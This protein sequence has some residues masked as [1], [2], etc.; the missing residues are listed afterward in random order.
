MMDL[1]AGSWLVLTHV[2]LAQECLA[3]RSSCVSTLTN[4][5]D[6]QRAAPIWQYTKGDSSAIK[7]VL[8]LIA[9]PNISAGG[10]TVLEQTDHF[11]HVQVDGKWIGVVDE[12]YFC[13]RKGHL[14]YSF[15]SRGPL[16]EFI[17]RGTERHRKILRYLAASLTARKRWFCPL[18]FDIR[19]DEEPS[20]P[21]AESLKQVLQL[22]TLKR[23]VS[24]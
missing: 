18:A 1:V 24:R 12:M 20:H 19:P 8:D 17:P 4:I 5:D 3:P 23:P 15:L 11:L 2:S 6:S 14:N 21:F 10:M 16:G 7:D 22:E 9:S 13:A